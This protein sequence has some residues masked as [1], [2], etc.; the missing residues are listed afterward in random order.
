MILPSLDEQPTSRGNSLNEEL[1]TRSSNQPINPLNNLLAAIG[2]DLDNPPQNTRA[3]VYEPDP[4][5]EWVTQEINITV[6]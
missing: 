3:M 5:A 2:H 1:K 4:E 6:K